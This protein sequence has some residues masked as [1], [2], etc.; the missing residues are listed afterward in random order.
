MLDRNDAFAL[1][2]VLGVTAI[3]ALVY[4]NL[5][6]LVVTHFDLH[7]RP[8]GWA[9]RET[10]SWYL[11]GAALLL[12]ALIRPGS[13]LLPAAWRERMEAS[14]TSAIAL[15]LAGLLGASQIVVL[16]VSLRPGSSA[17]GV[18]AIALGATWIAFGLLVP[19][20]RRN[21]FIGI[22]TTWTLS[23]DENWLRTHRFA[24]W[25]MTAGGFVALLGG[26]SGSAGAA[27]AAILSSVLVP[28]FYSYLLARRLPPEA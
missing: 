23:S 28:A 22:R 12:W 21:P 11:P 14:P 24:A 26:L 5:P 13:R 25:T 1:A 2:V 27:Y 7:G 3:T 15:M 4:P 17:G 20:V 10:G 8:N 9:P 18:I 19:R 6:P 16:Y